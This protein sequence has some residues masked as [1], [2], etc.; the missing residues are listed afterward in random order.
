MSVTIMR[1]ALAYLV[2]ITSYGNLSNYP[3]IAP[4]VY[5][6]SPGLD[7]WLFF[8][9][10]TYAIGAAFMFLGKKLCVNS[11]VLS[12]TSI[13]YASSYNADFAWFLALGLAMLAG[14]LIINN[15]DG[16]RTK[17]RHYWHKT[18]CLPAALRKNNR[19]SVK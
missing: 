12:V 14:Q 16:C 8:L 1:F 9:M 6:A 3:D 11:S 4:Y 18:R 5:H 19:L 15:T 13:L 7:L 2:L 10:I 17:A